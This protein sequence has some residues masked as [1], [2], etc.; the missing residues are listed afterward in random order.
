MQAKTPNEH[1]Q[2]LLIALKRQSRNP[3]GR[4]WRALQEHLLAPRRNHT[5]I[6]L[7]ALQRNF[8]KG[9]IMVVPGKV[10]ANGVVVDKL[11]V[12][13]LAFSTKARVKIETRGGKCLSLEELMQ[14]NP[15]G[16]DVKM[17][18]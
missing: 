11:Q 17:V 6:N 7:T 2:R 8:E 10:L 18:A 12:A 4:V 13:A 5:A 15:T 3:G 9:R 14:T 1:R 16:K